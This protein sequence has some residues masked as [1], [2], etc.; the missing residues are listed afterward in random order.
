M[1]ARTLIIGSGPCAGHVAMELLAQGIEISIAAQD[2]SA[3][4]SLPLSKG[5]AE[6]QIEILSETSVLA[7]RGSIGNFIILMKR[8]GENIRRTAANIIIAEEDQRKPN[9]SLYNLVPSPGVI[10]LSEV[11]KSLGNA[12]MEEI[13]ISS[14]PIIVFLTGLVRES[15]TVITEEIMRHCLELQRN[16]KQRTFILTKNL[17]IAGNGLEALYRKTK[18]AGAT[19]IKFSDSVPDIHQEQ[20]GRVSIEFVDELTQQ[21]F[22]L[23]P[24]VTVVDET[25]SPSGYLTDLAD[26][27]GLDRD[28]AGFV[29]T[30]NVH[31]I[32]VF[33]NRKG[34]TVAGPSRRIQPV[35]HHIVDA[36]NTALLTLGL[37]RNKIPETER[38]AEINSG[39][40]VRCLTCYRLCPHRAIMLDTC[41][42]IMPAA[43]EGCGICVAE[44][45]AL[46]INIK[47][48]G[49]T[50]ILEQISNRRHTSVPKPFVPFL[51]I[52]CCSRSASQAKQ[53]A[54]SMG[55]TLPQH[56]KVIEVPCAGS[57]SVN[58]LFSAFENNADGVLVLTCHQGNC[59]SEKGNIYA[60]QR[61]GG[62]IKFFAKIGV[63]KERLKISTLASN[64]SKEFENILIG[65]D[66]AIHD[67]GPSNL[68]SVF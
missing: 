21:A 64:M 43:C 24:H 60:Q 4:L 20:D 63:E 16:A 68:R 25:I 9:F 37:V 18:K 7:C 40:C 49:F 1:T 65:F 26:I 44:C 42:E 14:A 47:G 28:P 51:M 59:H 57:I 23:N 22:S 46:A 61:V 67:I 8:A 11:T 38:W 15:N 58:H 17:K 41:M 45:P 5:K 34:V 52:F 53:L 6:H 48:H 54:T 66:K 39:R 50:D 56:I 13:K 62:V 3:H 27:F 30:G 36:G 55:Y 35:G 10:S 32:S 33:T 12:T 2:K 19:Y 29:Q 31:R